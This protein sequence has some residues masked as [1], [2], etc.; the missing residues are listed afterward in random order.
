MPA[1]SNNGQV[2]HQRAV[3]RF[4][5][6]VD[7]LYGAAVD[8]RLQSSTQIDGCWRILIGST[9]MLVRFSAAVELLVAIFLSAQELPR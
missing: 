7:S 9:K 1:D 8:Y 5:V 3:S 6:S 2:W 4:D